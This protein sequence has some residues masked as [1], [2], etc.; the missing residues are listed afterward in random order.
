MLDPTLDVP[1]APA[2]IALIPGTIEVLGC[3]SELH[4][5]VAGEVLRLGL[6]P[7]L[8][9]EADQR[10]FVVAHNYA[11]VGPT[12]EGTAVF[13]LSCPHA[14]FHDFLNRNIWRLICRSSTIIRKSNDM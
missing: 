8:Q 11:G 6:A 9:P 13:R 4:N 12:D 14:R 10:R 7:F 3:G 5:Q 1:H 2:G